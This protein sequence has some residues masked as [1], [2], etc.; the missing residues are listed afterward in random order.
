[1]V[2]FDSY[3]TNKLLLT[4]IEQNV[5]QLQCPLWP[6]MEAPNST[7]VLLDLLYQTNKVQKTETYQ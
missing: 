1:M 6:D 3:D 2:N 4:G 7:S 5:Y